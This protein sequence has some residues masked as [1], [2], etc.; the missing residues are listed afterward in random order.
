MS[1]WSPNSPLG[2]A[3]F[4]A[5]FLYD[6]EQ[7]IIYSRRDALQR[8]FGYAYG[9][10]AEAFLINSIIDCEPIFFDYQGKTWMI[11][12]WKGQYGL[13]TG[14]EIGIYNRSPNSSAAY[15]M[16]DATIGK[17]PHDPNP[18]HNMFFD[19]A[20]DDEMLEMSFTLRRNGKK[21]FSRGPEKHWWLTGFKWGEISNPDDLTM[22]VEISFPNYEMANAFITGMIELKYGLNRIGGNKI[23]FQFHWPSSFQPR[24]DPAK[25]ATLTQV[26][27]DNSSIVSAYKRLNLSNNDPNLIP[28]DKTDWISSRIPYSETFFVQALAVLTKIVNRTM[29]EVLHTLV[30]GFQMALD[31]AKRLLHLP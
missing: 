5:G 28:H 29:E 24:K 11:E 25:A 18:S 17:R 4:A 1:Q 22:D 21:L 12:L 30:T 26:S 16:L 9:Y 19:C 14:C 23:G 7:D 13:M 27:S 2:N 20:N 8:K 15:A 6:I 10:D 31:E 3:V